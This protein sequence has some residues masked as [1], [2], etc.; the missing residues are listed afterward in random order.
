MMNRQHGDT[1]S[2]SRWASSAGLLV[3]R[4]RILAM[5]S[6]LAVA[7]MVTGFPQASSP[8]QAHVVK[9]HVRTVG[10]V[11]S[12]VAALRAAQDATR[13]AV[14]TLGARDPITTARAA[15]VTPVQD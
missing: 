8:A 6:V 3:R 9:S 12:A 14:S 15:A 10:F 4:G 13:S 7:P 2:E 5:A 1:F 11:K